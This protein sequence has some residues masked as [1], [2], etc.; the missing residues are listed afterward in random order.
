MI[1]PSDEPAEQRGLRLR[2]AERSH[3]VHLRATATSFA[4]LIALGTEILKAVALINGGAAGATLLFLSQSM[5]DHRSMALALVVPLAA[6]GF[7]LTVA[8]CATGWSYFS[9][10][11]YAEALKRQ[12]MTWSHPFVVATPASTVAAK[13][14]DF[15]RRLA[16]GAVFVAIA[17]AVIGFGAAGAI[18][19]TM[20]R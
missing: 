15:F 18:M 6:F 5:R 16:L 10:E 17:S 13:R 14:G 7:G 2:A 4:P 19:L 8:A 3:E 9:H 12:E 11:S 1:E 20:L